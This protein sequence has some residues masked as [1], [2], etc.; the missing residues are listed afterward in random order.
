MTC[1]LAGGASVE[2]I[3]APATGFGGTVAAMGLAGKSS[4][5]GLARKSSTAVDD[6]SVVRAGAAGAK[7]PIVGDLVHPKP[8]PF[9][10][11]HSFGRVARAV[12]HPHKPFRPL[13]CAKTSLVVD[14]V[15]SRDEVPLTA[16]E[17]FAD[18][19]DSYAPLAPSYVALAPMPHSSL[20]DA[21]LVVVPQQQSVVVL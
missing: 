17:A 8:P 1:G 21:A 16:D 4:P 5:T 19:V 10:P 9:S 12:V 18:V 11:G 3:A 15:S 13:P 14:V 2:A 6:P 7:I 20:G